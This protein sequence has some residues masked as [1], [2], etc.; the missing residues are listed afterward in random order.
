MNNH[1]REIAGIFVGASALLLI[2][3]EQYALAASLLGAML[4]FFIGEKNGEKRA[5]IEE[6][7]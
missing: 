1:Q 3:Q 7:T 4:G 5:K 6:T 2:Y